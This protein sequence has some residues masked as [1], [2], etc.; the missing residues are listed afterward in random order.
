MVGRRRETSWSGGEAERDRGRCFGASHSVA[1]PVGLISRTASWF[2]EASKSVADTVPVTTNRDRFP[3]PWRDPRCL[4]TLILTLPLS[5]NIGSPPLRLAALRW[6]GAVASGCLDGLL[7]GCHALLRHAIPGGAPHGI[8]RIQTRTPVAQYRVLHA[9][10][11]ANS[12]AQR[13]T[14]TI[15]PRPRS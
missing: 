13:Q 15:T 6:R 5:L 11:C 3:W 8:V 2:S 14:T 7:G 12:R 1:A 10:R 4:L 9:R